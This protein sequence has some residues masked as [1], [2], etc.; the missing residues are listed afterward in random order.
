MGVFY[1]YTYT[2]SIAAILCLVSG[3][4]PHNKQGGSRARVKARQVLLLEKKPRKRIK[5]MTVEEAVRAG[6]FY[7]HVK[8]YDLLPV[9]Y[10]HIIAKSQH[11]PDVAAAY[12]IKLAD[13]YLASNDFQ[14]AKKHY[15]KV[16]D[17]YPGY[18][19]IERARYREVLAH[20][21]SSLSPERD[22]TTTRATIQ[23]GRAYLK[24]FPHVTDS[25]ERICGMIAAS[26]RKLLESDMKVL[27]SYIKK[28]FLNTNNERPLRGAV[29]RLHT[30]RTELL[31][32]M[33]RFIPE[34]ASVRDVLV[35]PEEV[36]EA[37]DTIEGRTELAA[38]LYQ[39]LEQMRH[40]LVISGRAAKDMSAAQMRDR[41]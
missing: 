18:Q 40:T 39:K 8:N 37:I 1:R 31:P 41:F 21:W 22:Q 17:I 9:A 12:Y 28:Y 5:E 29:Q 27:E 10:Q 23:L 20:F 25:C 38:L 30:I 3:C 14:E 35:I 4:A 24:D 2:F 13:F 15:R 36:V 32:D 7:E 26:Y 6:E 33:V 16:I 11:E 19:G 34:A